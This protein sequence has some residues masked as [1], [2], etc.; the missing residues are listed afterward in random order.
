[1][2][3]TRQAPVAFLALLGMQWSIFS[4]SLFMRTPIILFNDVFQLTN[5]DANS[6]VDS[7]D[8]HNDMCR[9][10]LFG[11]D[12]AAFSFDVNWLPVESAFF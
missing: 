11:C 3:Q 4:R 12:L 8:F 10:A 2:L 6:A 7:I 9:A 1:M 5:G